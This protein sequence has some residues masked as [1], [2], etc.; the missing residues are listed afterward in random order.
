M[1]KTIVRVVISA[2]LL[3]FVLRSIDLGAFWLRVRAMNPGWLALALATYAS[4]VAVSVWRWERLLRTQHIEVARKTL[5]QSMWVS[6]FFNNFL[7]SNI[8]GD[9]IRIADTAAAAGSKTVA[10]TV[11]VADR[12]LGLA[13]LMVVAAIAAFAA[14]VSG[15]QVPGERWLALVSGVSVLV[16]LPFA[17]MPQLVSH[18][19]APVR[20]LKRPWVTERA[21]RLQDAV[22]K[23][24]AAPS[25][26]VAAFGGAVVVQVTIVGFYLLAAR[27]LSIPL[28][29]LLGAVLIP[30]SLVIQLAPVSINGFGVREAVFAFFFARFGLPADAAVALSL[31]A[32]GLVMALSLIGGLVF[33]GR[34]H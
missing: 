21:E 20:A 3:F 8:G 32:T 7:P 14:S 34:R 6:M 24:Y 13:A 16:V 10:T 28:P 5:T 27:A 30:V 2:A 17:L 22:L 19:L 26:L 18:L 33:L 9:V 29:V 11:V 1:L 25:A 31:V 4:T 15:I 23:F 12:A